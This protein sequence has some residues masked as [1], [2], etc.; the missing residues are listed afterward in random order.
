MQTVLLGRVKESRDEINF[1]LELFDAVTG[2][3]IWS[4]QYNRKAAN[5]ILLQNE[6]ALDLS[7]KI[8]THLSSADERRITKK[9][10]RVSNN[11]CK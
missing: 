2:N 4:R 1:N 6:A 5:F 10:Q 3:R 11:L 9:I 8:K 7:H